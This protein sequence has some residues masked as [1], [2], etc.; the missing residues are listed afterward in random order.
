MQYI[1]RGYNLAH[2]NYS[3]MRTTVASIIKIGVSQNT[4]CD[5]LACFLKSS[6]ILRDIILNNQLIKDLA[7]L[8]PHHQT[9]SL[10]SYHSIF[11]L[12]APKCLV[13]SHTGMYC[14]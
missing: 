13:F 3:G 14:R 10:K 6:H 9:S 2:E 12:F 11:S 5:K 1:W 8:S 7:K 4:K